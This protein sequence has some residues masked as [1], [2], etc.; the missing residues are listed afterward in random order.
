M[1]DLPLLELFNRLRAIGLPLGLRDYESVL[2]ALRGGYGLPNR[3]ALARLC[4]TLWVRTPA[5]QQVFNYYFERLMGEETHF[6]INRAEDTSTF[7]PDPTPSSTPKPSSSPTL[8]PSANP[9]SSSPPYSTHKPPLNHPEYRHQ[10]QSKSVSSELTAS[11]RLASE[12]LRET[13]DTVQV[14]Q[15]VQQITNPDGQKLRHDS[16]FAGDYF[17]V[18]QRQMKQSWR[19]LRRMVRTGLATEL[20]IKGT[21]HHI[22][23]NGMFLEPMFVARRTNQTELILLLDRDGSMVPFHSLSDLLA[24]TAFRG[25]RLSQTGIYYFH[26]CPLG[27]L[28][29]DPMHQEAI[30]VEKMLSRIRRNHTTVLFFSDAGAARSGLNLER[31]E[32]TVAFLKQLRRH[33][34]YLAWLNPVPQSRWSMTTAGG[35][36]RHVPMFEVTRPGLSRTIDALR[37]RHQLLP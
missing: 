18:T 25:G 11:T 29:R 7:P 33:I 12:L 1:D 20:D 16:R 5:E 10:S 26:N 37:G 22:A 30:P 27:Y 2:Q 28:Y 13:G 21:V 17:P 32:C 4:Q 31:I 8:F 36:A 14:A 19:Y 15:V 3:S 23:H 34:R 6:P 9:I 35:I 24:E